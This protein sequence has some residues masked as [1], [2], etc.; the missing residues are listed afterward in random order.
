MDERVIPERAFSLL[1]LL[2]ALALALILVTGLLSLFRVHSEVVRRQSLTADLQQ[3]LRIARRELSRVCRMAGRGGLAGAAALA[4]RNN[5]AAGDRIGG[6]GTPAVLPG[7]D[8]LIARG[9][10]EG[11]IFEVAAATGGGP[12]SGTLT[13]RRVGDRGELQNI[14]PMLEAAEESAGEALLLSGGPGS[15]RCAIVELVGAA[16]IARSGSGELAEL[17]LEYRSSGS[18][19]ADSYRDLAAVCEPVVVERIRNVGLLQEYRFY[20]R[21]GAGLSGSGGQH[22]LSRA[23]FYPG[24]DRV[25]PS[26]PA[27]GAPLVDNA[28]DLQLSLGVD[29]DRDGSVFEDPGRQ[30]SSDE[31]LFNDARDLPTAAHW[32]GASQRLIRLTLLLR[33]A[34]ATRGY[35]SPR[36]DRIEDRLYDE[37]DVPSSNHENRQFLRAR[38]TAT[39]KPRSG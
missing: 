12:G 32:S 2:V 5:A 10:F 30:R 37:Q 25:H 23:R 9:V 28:L 38:A 26:S 31:W 36:L 19:A 29:L 4:I 3:S 13:L 27:A 18:D 16:E 39:V 14:E 24:S 35:L 34:R 20:L 17:V 6:A 11:R 1:E 21:R 22:H 8:V 15:A 7:T 33:A